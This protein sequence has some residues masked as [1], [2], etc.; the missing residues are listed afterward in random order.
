[1]AELARRLWLFPGIIVFPGG[2]IGTNT[3]CGLCKDTSANGKKA[4]LF[5]L[6]NILDRLAV[7]VLLQCC[8]LGT[9]CAVVGVYSVRVLSAVAHIHTRRI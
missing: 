1:M 2:N 3:S 8:N 9:T 5:I 4:P 6:F 7:P